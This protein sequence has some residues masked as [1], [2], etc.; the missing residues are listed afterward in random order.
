VKYTELSED[1]KA[2]H[3]LFI[4][5]LKCLTP[6]SAIFHLYRCGQLYWWRKPEYPGKPPIYRK[7]LTNFY[8]IMLYISPWSRFELKTSVVIGTDCKVV[9]NP[10]TIR[11]RRLFQTYLNNIYF[12]VSCFILVVTNI[13]NTIFLS[14]VF[15]TNI[16][17]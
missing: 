15:K 9:V 17:N 4:W 11:S 16:Y 7:S 13:I 14:E 2:I 12:Y 3:M 10:T 8:H 5:L 6:L 1:A